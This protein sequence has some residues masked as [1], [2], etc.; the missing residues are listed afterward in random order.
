ME[1][2]NMLFFVTGLFLLAHFQG[3]FTCIVVCASTSFL[4]QNDIQ[5]FVHITFCFSIHLLMDI[6]VFPFGH[7]E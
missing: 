1:F 3:L 7:Y 6:W 4:F 2:Y 5:L